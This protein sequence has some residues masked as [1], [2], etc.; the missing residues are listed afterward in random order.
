MQQHLKKI[1]LTSMLLLFSLSLNASVKEMQRLNSEQRFQ[2]AFELGDK[3]LEDEA[4]NPNFDMAFGIAAQRAGEYDHAM[5]AFERVLMYDRNAQVPRFEL[6]R[7]HFM[8][9]NLIVARR[10]FNRLIETAPQPPAAVMKR[11]QWYMAAIKAKEA[12]GSVALSDAVT[13]LHLG[14]RLGFD[15]NPRNMTD[16]E[17]L[18]F[19]VL[20]LSM[21]KIESATYHEL[22]AGVTR[23]QQQGESW[24]WFAGADANLKGFHGDQSDMDNYSLGLQ[25][26]GILLGKD[27]RLSLP[28][29]VNKQVRDDKNEVLVLA[30]AAEFNQ[31]IDSQWDYTAFG[32]L[33]VIDFKPGDAR[34]AK[35]FT[36]GVIYSYRL[37]DKLKLYGGPVLGLENANNDEYSR[38]LFGVRTGAGYA[39]ND[40][41]RLDFNLSYL[42][43]SHKGE[44]PAF[45][46]KRNDDQL[47]MGIKFS[48]RHQTD[49]L[50][51]IGLNHS[52]HSSSLNLYSYRSTQLS[53][54]VRKEW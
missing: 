41:Q 46:K 47:G 50:F 17:V 38:N 19:D 8:L 49:W 21:P 42:S 6:A 45:L 48:H 32:Q 26:G 35:S 36:A 43:T 28:V 11:I 2:E 54:G 39:F 23:Y 13:R 10:H 22:L 18:L 51:D 15:S 5:F 1:I 9:G 31:R 33:A 7:T 40:K 24:G 44:D 14:A 52:N 25:G 29:Q 20:P 27:W 34:D 16:K 12:G 30:L 53:A 37:D 4:G 3:L